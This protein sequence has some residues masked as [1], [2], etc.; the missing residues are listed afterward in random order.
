MIRTIAV[1]AF[2]LVVVV[3]S[4]PFRA[5]AAGEKTPQECEPTI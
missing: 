1:A 3:T 2:A 5:F 4:A